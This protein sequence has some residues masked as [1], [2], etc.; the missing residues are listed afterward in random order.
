MGYYDT[1][2]TVEEYIKMAEG[3]DGRELVDAL[4]SHLPIG[5]TVLELGMGPGKD[6][7]ILG[8]SFQATGSDSSRVFVE[9]Y[10]QAHPKADLMVLDAASMD[11]DRRFDAIYS[12]KV[13]QHLTTA[14]L[15]D[16]LHRQAKVLN[17]SGIMLH[18]F[19][20]GDGEEEYSGLRFVYYTEESF[21]ELIGDEYDIVESSRYSEAETDDSI[22]FVLAKRSRQP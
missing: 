4:R 10:R 16:S 14:Q 9:R 12:N 8:E 6:L 20:Y 18:S 1:D 5:A 17:S 7:E 22:Y 3:I 21:G 15:E 13:L 11:T 19:W 2:E